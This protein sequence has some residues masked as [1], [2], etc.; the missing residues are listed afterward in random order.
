MRLAWF[1]RV[2]AFADDRHEIRQRAQSDDEIATWDAE[3]ET[4]EFWRDLTRLTICPKS[5]WHL[6]FIWFL[7]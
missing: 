6:T 1:L 5:Q 4:E 2:L 7:I 3:E